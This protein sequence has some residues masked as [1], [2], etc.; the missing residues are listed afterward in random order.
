MPR[1]TKKSK[2]TNTP[3]TITTPIPTVPVAEQPYRVPENWRWVRLSHI[4][5]ASKEKTED[6]SDNSVRYVGLENMEKDYGI[7]SYGS[8]NNV[9]SLKN[10]FSKGQVLY[11]KLRPYLNKHDVA[12]FDGICSTDIIVFNVKNIANNYFV[13]QFLNLQYFIEYASSNSKGI[14]LPRVSE[15][16][17]LNAIFP[18]PPLA[19]QQRIVDRIESQFAKLDEARE[20]AQAVV[21]GFEDRKAA[22][23]H[24]A[25][26]GEL[27]KRWREEN[28]ADSSH[29]LEQIQLSVAKKKKTKS[30]QNEFLKDHQDVIPSEWVFVD[31]NTIA[32]LITDGEHKTP[33]RVAEFCGYYLLSARNVINDDIKLNDVDYIDEN[34]FNKI[35]RRCNPK[36]GDILISCS[37]SVGR[38]CV[39]Q[40]NNKYCMVRSAAMVSQDYCNARFIMFMIQS[41]EVQEQ[42][43]QLSKQTAQANLF[44]G[45]IASLYIPL[46]TREEQ[47]L[48]VK[49]VDS[50]LAKEQRARDLAESVIAQIDVMKKAILARA[51]RGELGTNDTS[52]SACEM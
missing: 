16:I 27:T 13:N 33:N 38:C 50:L 28:K 7:V 4:I 2:T 34:E 20:K 31:L 26:T 41:N 17:I 44:L 18:L 40:D 1:I 30:V 5:E 3:Q 10:V 45:A 49:T 11:G 19:E 37:G 21:D 52:E 15:S 35:S 42:I 6:F 51:F 36:F 9:K 47:N 23:L 43:K 32:K 39:V 12:S 8:A 46:P 48:I 25:F 29:Y 14:N 24:K 22:I